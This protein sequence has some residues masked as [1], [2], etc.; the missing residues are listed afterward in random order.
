MEMPKKSSWLL[1]QT[2]KS[3]S[4]IAV[5]IWTVLALRYCFILA[6]KK[7]DFHFNSDLR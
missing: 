5:E 7:F 2:E 4:N 3:I 6:S 1:P